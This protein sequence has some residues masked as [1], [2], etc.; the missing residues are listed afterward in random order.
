MSQ[1]PQE[2]A[3]C[4][5]DPYQSPQITRNPDGS[6][7]RLI[8]IPTTAA[9]LDPDSPSPVL[10][11]DLP[12]NPNNATFLRLYLPRKST[13]LLPKLGFRRPMTTPWKLW[14]G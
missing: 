1:Q 3:L 2:Q 9:S 14:S 12:L 8:S 11:K 6:I 7:T 13:V 5:I 10:S 4:T